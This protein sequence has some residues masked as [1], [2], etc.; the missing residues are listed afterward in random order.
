MGRCF[1]LE[2]REILRGFF[3]GIL[4]RNIREEM[5]GMRDEGNWE[6]GKLFKGV[7]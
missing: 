4:G 6:Y 1:R 5:F 7:R 2:L 3:L